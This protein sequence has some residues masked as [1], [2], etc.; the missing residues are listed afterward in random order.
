MN[1]YHNHHI[2]PRHA[3]GTDDP[4][5]IVKLTVEEHAEAH[6][7]LYEKYGRWQDHVAWLSL[8]KQIS[9]AEAIK[10]AQS[11]ANKGSNNPMFGM[12]GEKNPNYGNRGEKNPMFGKKQ[13]EETCRKKRLSLINRSYEDLHGKEKSEQIKN[14][15]RKP[16]TQ[17]HKNKL[18]KPKPKLVCRIF[19]KKEMALGNFS[20]W[21]RMENNC[22]KRNRN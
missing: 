18:K 19:D 5:N 12:F 22:G 8:S 3:G 1:I 9:C 15:L 16:K 10:L 6:R 11:N 7:I 2:V 20:N 17:E 13:T 21:L 4:S 14:K